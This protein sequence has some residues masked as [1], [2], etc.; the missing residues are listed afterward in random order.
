MYLEQEEK[1]TPPLQYAKPSRICLLTVQIYIVKKK[2]T[3]KG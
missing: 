3:V 1:S 2:R